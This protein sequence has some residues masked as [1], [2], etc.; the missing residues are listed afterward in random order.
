MWSGFSKGI[1]FKI[2]QKYKMIELWWVSYIDVSLL[3]QLHLF[4]LLKKGVIQ[5]NFE[6]MFT[7]RMWKT[8]RNW[9]TIRQFQVSC[10]QFSWHSNKKK[11]TC[12]RAL[13]AFSFIYFVYN[14]CLQL[15]S[16]VSHIDCVSRL[17]SI[18][19]FDFIIM[20]KNKF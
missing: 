13:F 6:N 3:I 1:R 12:T 16:H 14:A 11:K 18:F 17:L 2:I 10:A 5:I 7:R 8:T 20:R 19:L 15:A 4:L 9:R